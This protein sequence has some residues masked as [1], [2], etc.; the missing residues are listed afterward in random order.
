MLLK[1]GIFVLPGILSWTNWDRLPCNVGADCGDGGFCNMDNYSSGYCEK[2]D[3]FSVEDDCYHD[4]LPQRGE[5][6]CV[7]RC[8]HG[9][10]DSG[11]NAGGGEECFS[12]QDC[13]VGDGMDMA[14]FCNFDVDDYVGHCQ[15]CATM[16]SQDECYNHGL[17]YRGEESCF[18]KCNSRRECH[19]EY[20]CNDHEFCNFDSDWYGHC[21]SCDHFTSDDTCHF[22]LE[23][24]STAGAHSCLKSCVDIY[25]TA[26]FNNDECP[27]YG[28]GH[29]SFCN[30]KGGSHG[31]CY[32][33]WAYNDEDHCRQWYSG[34]ESDGESN[35]RNTCFPPITTTTTTTTTK[36]TTTAE[37]EPVLVP[38][39]VEK[40]AKLDTFEQFDSNIDANSIKSHGCHC[41]TYSGNVGGGSPIDPLDAAC[42]AW[43][44]KSHCLTLEGGA[45]SNGIDF[46]AYNVQ[47]NPDGSLNPDVDFGC[48]YVS[49]ECEEAVCRLAYEFGLFLFGSVADAGAGSASW[50]GYDANAKCTP[51]APGID[52][53]EKVCVGDSPDVKIV[54]K[55]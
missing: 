11:Q 31:Y 14:E 55:N 21:E 44:I 4:G 39:P 50:L 53:G 3:I 5:E 49:N 30:Y 41:S 24:H 40:A 18:E 45:C 34:F 12:P 19:S 17:S 16:Q 43:N 6:N 1:P 25:K 33:C 2:C 38:C 52:N 13:S 23:N 51:V 47:V 29:K 26:C 22:N 7:L 48:A 46:D 15:S 37:P 42:Q 32:D 20:D 10:D 36:P 8:I 28:G 27:N 35:C 9:G 54:P